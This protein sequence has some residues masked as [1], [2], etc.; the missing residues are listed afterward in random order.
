MGG[1]R[2]VC[3]LL[4]FVWRGWGKTHAL[5][6]MANSRRYLLVSQLTK[7]KEEGKKETVVS[8]VQG[9]RKTNRTGHLAKD[10]IKKKKRTC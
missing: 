1:G 9:N 4:W 8:T 5:L 10:V 3:E 6:S 2:G 7:R